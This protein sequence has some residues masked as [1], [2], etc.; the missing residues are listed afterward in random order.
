MRLTQCSASNESSRYNTL[1]A[2]EQGAQ[3]GNHDDQVDSLLSRSRNWRRGSKRPDSIY[4]PDNVHGEMTM[5]DRATIDNALVDAIKWREDL[6]D[7]WPKGSHQR[8]ESERRAQ[9]YRSMLGRRRK[10]RALQPTDTAEQ[11][12]EDRG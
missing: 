3:V 12:K 6:A 7:A 9:K 10:S 11:S 4:G 8:A 2:T 5:T 1:L